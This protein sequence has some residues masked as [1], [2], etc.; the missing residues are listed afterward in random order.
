MDIHIRKFDAGDEE[1]VKNVV[2]EALD[3]YGRLDVFF[4]NAGISSKEVFYESNSE[5]FMQMMKTNALRY[6]WMSRV[7]LDHHH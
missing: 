2:Q 4:A 6:V 5:K 7:M 3:K 1:S